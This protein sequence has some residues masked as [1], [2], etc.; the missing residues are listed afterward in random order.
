PDLAG[1]IFGDSEK[2]S[3]FINELGST[4]EDWKNVDASAFSDGRLWG[5]LDENQREQ[6]LKN[7]KFTPAVIKSAFSKAESGDVTENDE[8]IK[9]LTDVPLMRKKIQEEE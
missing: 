1:D 6:V 8:E 4:K 7:R 9:A 5:S 3:K 2:A